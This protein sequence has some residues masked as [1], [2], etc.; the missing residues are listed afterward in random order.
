MTQPSALAPVVGNAAEHW[1]IGAAIANEQG[2]NAT[3][4]QTFDTHAAAA[5]FCDMMNDRLGLTTE[6]AHFI[7]ISTMGGRVYNETS[8]S[9]I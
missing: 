4:W 7:I 5:D 2:Y 9:Q 6:Q 1:K 8:G 3:T